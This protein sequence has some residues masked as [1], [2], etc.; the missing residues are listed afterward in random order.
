MDAQ[1][2]GEKQTPRVQALKGRYMST[3]GKTH[4][5]HHKSK[6][7]LKGR[8]ILTMSK[9]HRVKRKQAPKGRYML[10][11]G[12][13]H[14]IHHKCEQAPKGRHNLMLIQLLHHLHGYRFIFVLEHK[15]IHSAF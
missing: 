10:T 8:Y 5:V 12:K 4:R 14:R 6:Q 2:I 9:T 11:M 3:V 7:A 13:T 15:Q 1:S